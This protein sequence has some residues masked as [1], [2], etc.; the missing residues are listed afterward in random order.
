[1]T[2]QTTKLTDVVVYVLAERNV[3]GHEIAP[4]V[5]ISSGEGMLHLY[6]L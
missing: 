4:G 1:M 2:T 6:G 5:G 3:I